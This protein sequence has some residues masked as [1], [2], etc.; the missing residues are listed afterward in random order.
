M[1]A[2]NAGFMKAARNF[3]G[4]GPAGEGPMTGRGQGLCAPGSETVPPEFL[5][6]FRAKQKAYKLGDPV[7]GLRPENP[8][9]RRQASS[10][11]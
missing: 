6:W 4:T 10:K 7:Q 2:F 8:A 1:L 11:D 3:D 5:K 9:S